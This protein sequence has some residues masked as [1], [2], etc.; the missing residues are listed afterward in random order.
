MD[1]DFNSSVALGNLHI[2][3]KYV[4]NLINTTKQ[5]NKQV[6]ANTLAKILFLRN[7]MAFWVCLNK[8]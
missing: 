1:D 7:F 5:N 2:I 3:F 6:I 4:N 8:N